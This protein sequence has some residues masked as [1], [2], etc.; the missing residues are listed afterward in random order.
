MKK[1]L[2]Y[3]LSAF[4]PNLLNIVYAQPTQKTNFIVI[5]ADDLGY[6]DIGVYGS[7]L[8]KTPNLDQW[9]NEALGLTVFT[10]VQTCA[11]LLGAAY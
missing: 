10:P 7:E 9:P 2:I 1:I 4:I 6:G 5:M 3:C 8:I 11:R